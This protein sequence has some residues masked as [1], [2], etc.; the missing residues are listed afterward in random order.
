MALAQVY[1][2]MMGAVVLCWKVAPVLSLVS[3][4]LMSVVHWGLGDT[5]EDLV[6]PRMFSLEV[7]LIDSL[8][9]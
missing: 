5:E 8:L 4:L 7:T 9:G 1:L 6:S 2:G 3:F